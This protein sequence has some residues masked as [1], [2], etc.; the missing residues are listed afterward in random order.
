MSSRSEL[1][2]KERKMASRPGPQWDPWPSSGGGLEGE[3]ELLEFWVK[4]PSV[5]FD[6]YSDADEYTLRD[7]SSLVSSLKRGDQRKSRTYAEKLSKSGIQISNPIWSFALDGRRASVKPHPLQLEA[8]A[9]KHLGIS[10]LKAVGRDSEDFHDIGVWQ[11]KSALEAAWKVG[12]FHASRVRPTEVPTHAQSQLESIARKELGLE[13]LRTRKMDDLDFMYQSPWTLVSALEAAWVAGYRGKVA[14]SSKLNQE[15]VRRVL[16]YQG[17]PVGSVV[18]YKGRFYRVITSGKAAIELEFA[19]GSSSFWVSRKKSYDVTMFSRQGS[20]PHL[21]YRQYEFL[22]A[23]GNYWEDIFDEEFPGGDEILRMPRSQVNLAISEAKDYAKRNRISIHMPR[24]ERFAAMDARR[25][26]KMR[27]L[28]PEDPRIVEMVR[29]QLGRGSKPVPVGTGGENNHIRFH[30]FRDGI[31]V[32]DLTNAGRRGKVVDLFNLYDL[33]FMRHAGMEDLVD[34][35]SSTLHGSTYA[36]ALAGAQALV[37]A[38]AG[39]GARPKIQESQVKGVRVDPAG[40]QPVEVKGSRVYVKAEPQ[41]FVVRDLVDTNNEPV[42]MRPQRAA[43]SNAKKFYAWALANEDRI[44]SMSFSDVRKS[45]DA[46]K[47]KYHYFLAMD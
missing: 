39:L 22:L 3:I 27:Q 8:I 28:N 10:S 12:R 40:S 44:S 11:I 34:H 30:R 32:Y 9:K 20:V 17:F 43:K 33:D 23:V 15:A 37:A 1:S 42:L 35:Y 7:V 31:R 45:L 13:T 36:K 26:E 4:H 14:M 21:T 16:S 29:R 41:D 6:L 46:S 47:I 5:F 38:S 24:R 19:D 2:H 25:L 18:V